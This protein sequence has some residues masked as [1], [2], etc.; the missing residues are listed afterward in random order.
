MVGWGSLYGES[1]E[2]REARWR[3]AAKEAE[4][5]RASPACQFMNKSKQAWN[6][7]HLY[8]R[9]QHF[10]QRASIDFDFHGPE[11]EP[12]ITYGY[13]ILIRSVFVLPKHRQKGV[14]LAILDRCKA[15][16]NE[17]GC[18]LLAVC[19]P[20]KYGWDYDESLSDIEQL[21]K[22]ADRFGWSYSGMEMLDL[23][24]R[25]N[26]NKQIRM[27]RRFLDSGFVPVDIRDGMGDPKKFGN[28]AVAYVPSSTPEVYRNVIAERLEV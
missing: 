16:A 5:C 12:R 18:V 21:E 3:R 26:K 10:E 9:Y 7:P 22:C 20:F 24:K 1:W 8:G 11:G 15:L 25:T 4:D 6:F 2:G 13:S 17:T 23:K 14:T 19:S 28:W 27:K